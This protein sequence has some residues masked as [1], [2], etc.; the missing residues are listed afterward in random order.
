MEQP[1]ALEVLRDLMGLARNSVE[2][3]HEIFK[4]CNDNGY[5]LIDIEFW[6]P[7]TQPDMDQVERDAVEQFRLLITAPIPVGEYGTAN[8]GN[9]PTWDDIISGR[10]KRHPAKRVETSDGHYFVFDDTVKSDGA[11]D[12]AADD[13]TVLD[14]TSD[15]TRAV[16]LSHGADALGDEYH[17]NLK[18]NSDDPHGLRPHPDGT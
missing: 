18:R 5:V 13:T 15:A 2:L 17:R 4:I 7:Q 1:L 14:L 16:P 8:G 6:A 12:G 9:G 3:R 11:A 10:V